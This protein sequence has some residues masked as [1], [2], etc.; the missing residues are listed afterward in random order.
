MLFAAIAAAIAR[1]I[2]NGGHLAAPHA[3]NAATAVT[4]GVLGASLVGDSHAGAMPNNDALALRTALENIAH[5]VERGVLS[6]AQDAYHAI[7]G[8]LHAFA[9]GKVPDTADIEEV[10]ALVSKGRAAY[11]KLMEWAHD[12]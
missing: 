4:H 9:A 3:V 2:T 10:R 1:L 5:H 6:N 12:G 8:C 11:A 7:I